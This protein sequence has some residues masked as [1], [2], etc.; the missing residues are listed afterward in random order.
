[1]PGPPVAGSE[2]A[3]E[4]VRGRAGLEPAVA[5]AGGGERRDG[6]EPE[7]RHRRERDPG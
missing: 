1:M 3:P 4:G 7:E 2:E 5:A 6:G